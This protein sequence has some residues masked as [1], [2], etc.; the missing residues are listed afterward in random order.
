VNSDLRR[1]ASAGLALLLVAGAVVAC[2]PAA[3]PTPDY[4][5]VPIGPTAW[6]NGTTG[7]YGL[8]ID[9][10]LLAKLPGNV[11]AHA[12]VEDAGDEMAAMDNAD[13]AKNF[14]AYAAASIGEPTDTDWLTL[15]IGHVKPEI[16]FSDFYSSWADQYAT[17]ACSQAN[18]VT[19]SDQVQIGD[20]QVDR[21]YCGG[22][23]LVY[24][25]SLGNGLILSLF[26]S[27]PADLSR[28]L[29]QAIYF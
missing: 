24:S 8:H 4:T 5:Q 12:L 25:L 1:R 15:S 29:I 13:L 14:D 18:G 7:Q 28:Q 21:S 16:A 11:A 3:S 9:P 23:F 2:G 26:G 22:G 20:W 10:T 27:G 17:G 6:P 19:S